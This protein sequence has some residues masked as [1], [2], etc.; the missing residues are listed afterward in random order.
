MYK[1]KYFTQNEFLRSNTAKKYGI[2][3]IPTFEILHNLDLLV[4]HVLDPLREA[5]GKPI[6]VNSGYR[7]KELNEKIGGSKT[8]RHMF[9]EA[10]DITTGSPQENKKLYELCKK[11]NL[12]VDQAINEYGYKWLHLSY[13]YKNRRM[14]IS[15]PR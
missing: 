12:P 8:S 4:E 15:L 1:Y 2:A 11:L 5:Y 7:C 3:N 10:A 13:G 6:I 9:G 14:Y